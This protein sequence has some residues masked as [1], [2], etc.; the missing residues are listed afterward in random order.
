MNKER[1]TANAYEVVANRILEQLDKGVIPWHRPW[2]SII[3]EDNSV[4]PYSYATGKAYRGI[5]RMILLHDDAYVT[6]LECKKRGG[7]IRKGAHGEKVVYWNMSEIKELDTVTGEE[8]VKK[9]PLLKMSTV[10]WIGDTEGLVDRERVANPEHA[11]RSTDADEIIRNYSNGSSVK[12]NYDETSSAYYRPMFDDIHVPPIEAYKA[13]DTAE[14][15]STV[16]HEMTHSTGHKDRLDRFGH[17]SQ[18]NFGSHAYSKE[19]LVA[20][21]GAAMLVNYVGLETESSFQNS[22]SYIDG[23]M[24]A[25]RNDPKLVLQAASKAEKAAKYILQYTE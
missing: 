17:K 16:F 24:N 13:G 22:A 11:E 21:I 2:G 9:I 15:Y 7:K 4:G 1:N 10:F 18:F 8:K 19:E 23:W 14:F 3:S 25:I 12:V 20:E 6:F 5:N